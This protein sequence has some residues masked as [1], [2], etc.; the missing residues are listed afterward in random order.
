MFVGDY[1]QGWVFVTNM[2][3]SDTVCLTDVFLIVFWAT[4]ERMERNKIYQA[5][6]TQTI[7]VRRIHSLLVF[8]IS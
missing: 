7:L 3:V 8:I 6:D 5:L 4:M 1:F 2:S